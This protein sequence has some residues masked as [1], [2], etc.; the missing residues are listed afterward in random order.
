MR[1]MACLRILSSY[2]PHLFVMC[3]AKTE[4]PRKRM[5]QWWPIFLKIYRT[6]KERKYQRAGHREI[7]KHWSKVIMF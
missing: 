5:G 2:L 6:E 3:V 7:L 1:L 4:R